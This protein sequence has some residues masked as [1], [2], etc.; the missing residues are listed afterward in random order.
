M[1]DMVRLVLQVVVILA[2]CQAI[3]ILFARLHQ[4]RVVGEMVAGIVLGPSL[5]GWLAPGVSGLIFPPQSLG[6]LNALSQL[7]LIVFMF[8][9][10]MRFDPRELRSN[11][12]ATVLIS[13]V[14]VAL[15]FVSGAF[16]ALYLYPR[17]SDAGV[18]FAGFALF[19]GTALSI[20]AFPV[21]AR[22]LT[23]RELLGSRLSHIALA[24]AAINDVIGW[25]ILAGIMA[26]LRAGHGA[27]SAWL[28]LGGVVL[29]V[30]A[31]FVAVRPLLARFETAYRA[32]GTLGDGV[33]G[34]MLM[35]VLACAFC[36]E[37]LGI[38]LIFG[39]FLAG[40]VMPKGSA[41]VQHVWDRLSGVTIVLLLPLFFAFTGLRTSIGSLGRHPD[42][43]I[44]CGAIVLVATAGKLGGAT[45]AARW[46]GLPLREAAA[47]GAMMNT[48][49]L[50]EL[51]ILNIGLDVGV[52]GGQLF[53]MMVIMAVGTT[54]MTTPLL[55]ALGQR[56]VRPGRAD[57]EAGELEGLA[58]ADVRADARS[59]NLN[60]RTKKW[61][62]IRTVP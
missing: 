17:F 37:Q 55:V 38:H 32:R 45:V 4:P 12:Y 9:V 14:S 36:T 30:L 46:A 35:L 23:D 29:F 18:P 21:L 5:L 11:G 62:R 43:W 49:G 13:H 10:G 59:R 1:S 19:I 51:L 44:A 26:V 6:Y 22:I 31:L 57:A 48:R 39:A 3:G 42:A 25:C 33:L 28:A 60:D 20:T 27:H 8:L 24:C 53:S 15:P 7:G 47:V 2:A 61:F 40:V 16:L 54:L 52:I 50:M 41:F 34:L 56:A 58:I